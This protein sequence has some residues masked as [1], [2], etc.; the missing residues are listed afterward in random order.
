LHTIG[1]ATLLL[2]CA[3]IFVHDL[4]V[5]SCR[6]LQGRKLEYS[7]RAYLRSQFSNQ[8]TRFNPCWSVPHVATPSAE[9]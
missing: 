7:K 3:E 2:L 9:T 4:D 5:V 6:R 8:W 1:Q